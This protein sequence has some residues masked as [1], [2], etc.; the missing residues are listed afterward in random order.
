MKSGHGQSI[1]WVFFIGTAVLLFCLSSC[2]QDPD[3]YSFQDFEKLEKIDAHFHYNVFDTRFLEFADSLNFKIASPN[4]RTIHD[5][6]FAVACSIKKKFPENFAFWGTFTLEN[7]NQPVFLQQ[8]IER[9]EMV[10]DS[11]AIGIKIWKDLGMVLQDSAGKYIMVDDPVFKPV[12]DYLEENNITVI[13]HFGEP[14]N[15]W[16]PG[17]E[18]TVKSNR[19]YYKKN[20]QYHMY[21]HPEAPSYEEQITARDNMLEQHPRLNF[22]GAHLGSLEW[23]VEEL[24]KRLDRFPNLS[25]DMAGRVNHLQYQSLSNRE[26]VRDFIIKYQDRILYATDRSIRPHNTDLESVK[27]NVLKKWKTEWMFLAT[28]TVFQSPMV[29]DQM[30][31]GLKLPKKVIDKI[32][33]SNAENLFIPSNR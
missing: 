2:K 9:V 5:D 21:L 30:V 23:S 11:G 3:F 33:Y 16:L 25:V 18:M 32:Y 27:E 19:D 8:T 12:F 22:I 17:E 24:A 1:L 7:W 31:M 29:Y 14:K 13:G 26:G 6:Q 10:L 28:D 4:T 20:P 15:C